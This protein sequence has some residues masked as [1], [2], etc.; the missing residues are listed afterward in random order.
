MRVSWFHWL[1]ILIILA[2]TALGLLWMGRAPIC[3]CGYLRL[4]PAVDVLTENSQHLSDWYTPSHIIHGA[5]L[6]A[7]LWAV[8]AGVPF[9]TRMVIATALEAGWELLENSDLIIAQYRADSVTLGFFGDSVVNSL[10]D[11]VVMI[12]GFYMAAALPV[13]AS[14]ALMIG[15]EVLTFWLIRDGLVLIVLR[16]IL[17]FGPLRDWLPPGG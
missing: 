17:P 1:K 3:A 7:A 2:V 8:A 9:N 12:G 4:W 16:Y 14:V 13:A 10:T 11:I 5:L 6:Y 15:L